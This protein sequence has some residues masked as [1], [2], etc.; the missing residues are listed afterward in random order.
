MSFAYY[1]SPKNCLWFS[2]FASEYDN[3]TPCIPRL[4]FH[5]GHEYLVTLRNQTLIDLESFLN[6]CPQ[7]ERH[8]MNMEVEEFL[9]NFPTELSEIDFDDKTQESW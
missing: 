9:K 6:M 5:C 3:T 7:C 2:E 8:I 4:C 1:L